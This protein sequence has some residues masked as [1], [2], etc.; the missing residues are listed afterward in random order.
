MQPQWSRVS[1][2]AQSGE[3][4]QNPI[5]T[6]ASDG[7]TVIFDQIEDFRAPLLLPVRI[8][9]WLALPA[10]S[11]SPPAGRVGRYQAPCNPEGA[12]LRTF[13]SQVASV[14]LKMCMFCR[15]SQSVHTQKK[16]LSQFVRKLRG[17]CRV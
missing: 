12:P 2:P 4:L 6:S 15:P 10:E 3:L 16:L 11:E 5:K 7:A 14:C 1:N 8:A 13:R 17:H 9:S